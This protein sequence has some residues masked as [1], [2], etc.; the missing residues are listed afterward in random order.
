DNFAQDLQ[1]AQYPYNYVFIEPSYDVLNEYKRGSS[2]HPRGD[3]TRGEA[4]IK[5]TYEA[6]RNSPH[7][8]SSVL[9]VTW[10]EHGG[11]FDHQ[12]PP[13]AVPPGDTGQHSTHNK[14]GF[15]FA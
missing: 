12:P 10:D 8:T 7:W 4:L 11:F 13:I 5:Q 14:S 9:I 2:Q 3:V 1:A 6:I 15:T